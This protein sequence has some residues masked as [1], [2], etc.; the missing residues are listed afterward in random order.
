MTDDLPSANPLRAGKSAHASCRRRRPPRGPR[1]GLVLLVLLFSAFGAGSLGAHETIDTERM[2]A[3]LAA[4]A[5]ATA[6]A[7][8]AGGPGPEGEARFALGSVLV[9][10]TDILNRDLA[11]HSGRLAFNAEYL[12]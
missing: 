9:E 3:L 5:E 11:A 10:A 12:L 8:T 1:S 4:A 6:G 7:K 2:N